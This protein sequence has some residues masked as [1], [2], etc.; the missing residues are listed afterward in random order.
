M[1]F[2]KLL[3]QRG[4]ANNRSSIIRKFF[5]S[6]N[7]P[8]ALAAWLMYSNGEHDQLLKLDVNPAHYD[9]AHDFHLDYSVVSYL[10][11]SQFLQTSFDK[12]S[13]CLDKFHLAEEQCRLTNKRL[14][15]YTAG[16][17]LPAS[18]L[19]SLI[20]RLRRKIARILGEFDYEELLE[21]SDWGPGVTTLIKGSIAVKPNKYQHE[22]GITQEVLDTLYPILPIAY[23]GWWE[24]ILKDTSFTVE[25][26]NVFC[27]V[28]K[29]SKTKRAIFIEPGFNLFFQ[30]GIGRMIRRRLLRFGL[31]LKHQR[32]NQLLASLAQ[33]LG[34]ATIDFSMASDTIARELVRLLIPHSWYRMLD[35]LR[36]KNSLIK[37]QRHVPEKFSS[38]G[39][40][41][42]FELE[43]LI[44]Y[45]LAIVCTEEVHGTCDKELIG[46]Y[47]DDVIVS[48]DVAPLY[49]E[50]AALLG[51]TINKDKSFLSG[52]FFE[53]CGKHYFDSF[54]VTPIY[55]KR[56]LS[57]VRELY[58]HH[59]SVTTLSRR[60]AMG[61][62][63][64]AQFRPV[65]RR[66][67]AAIP[68]GLAYF[69][70]AYMGDS[71]LHENYQSW[72]VKPDKRGNPCVNAISEAPISGYFD[73]YGLILDRVRGTLSES[74]HGNMV[75]YRDRK[76]VV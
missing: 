26:G 27:A 8:K 48:Q 46:T 54:D 40:G 5:E 33:A 44:F 71:V 60:F 68:S 11:K 61:V 39:N 67:R 51:F 57:D 52:R 56:D 6:I 37:G 12:E 4:T 62:G 58:K 53:S 30:K 31:S 22:T 66:I 20:P 45:A 24:N 69:G 23:P 41:F 19:H 42:T 55:L 3:R 18:E 72:M 9:S 65:I 38:M 32:R 14:S 36:S 47:G 73:G 50:V 21:G 59:N 34:L 25:P 17:Y 43:S 63:R 15:P 7:T 75:D 29:N 13:V 64:S 49:C 16:G 35:L 2:A 74:D 76:S 28:E 1:S 10:S 70:P